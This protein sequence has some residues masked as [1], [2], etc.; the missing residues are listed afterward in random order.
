MGLSPIA[1]SQQTETYPNGLA[2]AAI[3]P[4]N[5]LFQILV[6]ASTAPAAQR[7]DPKYFITQNGPVLYYDLLTTLTTTEPYDDKG[8]Y[9]IDLQL[10]PPSGACVGSS[11]YD[12]LN[13]T[14]PNCTAGAP[15]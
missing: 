10:G 2:V 5:P 11:A 3:D 14:W 6:P 4:A 15:P 8:I 9:M 1:N 12:G 7:L 13:P